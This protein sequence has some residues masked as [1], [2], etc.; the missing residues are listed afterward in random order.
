VSFRDTQQAAPRF[1]PESLINS[2]TG[3][4]NLVKSTRYSRARCRIPAGTAWTFIG[5]IEPDVVTEGRR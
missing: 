2:L 1:T 4:V 5:G 3:R